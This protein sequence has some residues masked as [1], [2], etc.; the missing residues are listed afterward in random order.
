MPA[1]ST[2]A[3][4]KPTRM[5]IDEMIRNVRKSLTE[6]WPESEPQVIYT[7]KEM[8]EISFLLDSIDFPESVQTYMNTF[9]KRNDWI[10]RYKLVR[11][12][13]GWGVQTADTLV[14]SFR[15]PWKIQSNVEAYYT[16]HPEKSLTQSQKMKL[17]QQLQA[18][19]NPAAGQGLQL[20]FA[21]VE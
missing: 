11:A 16:I 2:H 1:R 5:L 6:D 12:A 9:S 3:L 13:E 21:S 10:E 18:S 15:P 17:S 19:S 4:D 7:D 14:F 20:S 8:F